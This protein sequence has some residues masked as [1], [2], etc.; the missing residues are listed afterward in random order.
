MSSQQS[1]RKTR[2]Q[3]PR[4]EPNSSP[5]TIRS[6]KKVGETRLQLLKTHCSQVCI[7]KSPNPR[8]TKKAKRARDPTGIFAFQGPPK[9]K[10]TSTSEE[11]KK[12]KAERKRRRR[13][14]HSQ[15][16]FPS[17]LFWGSSHGIVVFCSS[18]SIPFCPSVR[19]P[20]T[21]AG[22]PPLQSQVEY[23]KGKI[24]RKKRGQHVLVGARSMC[25]SLL[26]CTRQLIQRFGDV[27]IGSVGLTVWHEGVKASFACCWFLASPDLL[28]QMSENS[29]RLFVACKQECYTMFVMFQPPAAGPVVR[30]MKR[31]KSPVQIKWS[32][33]GQVG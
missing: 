27:P 19:H 15:I 4:I 3:F 10:P 12:K 33:H 29:P 16:P 24:K 17:S 6:R 30:S 1:R 31:G 13:R 21:D 2:T 26:P 9:P 22:N 28:F 5:T 14:K 23:R 20:S 25:L 32:S 7:N 11:K 18:L 8:P